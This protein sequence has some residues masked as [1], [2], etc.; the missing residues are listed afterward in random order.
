MLVIVILSLNLHA[1][2]W[3]YQE[4]FNS[5]R[6]DWNIVKGAVYD[7]NI[8]R[9][10][11]SIRLSAWI[12]NGRLGRV[13]LPVFPLNDSSEISIGAWSAQRMVFAQ[14]PYYCGILAILFFDDDGKLISNQK[15]ID[16]SMR[17]PVRLVGLPLVPQGLAWD[18]YSGKVKVPS[19]AKTARIVY[20][21]SDFVEKF[22]SA[23]QI[24]GEVW[25]DDVSVVF[26]RP[27]DKMILPE[28]EEKNSVYKL[29]L[30]TPVEINLFTDKDP[31]QFDLLLYS[32]NGKELSLNEL[33]NAIVKYQVKDYLYK[34]ITSGEIPFLENSN[35][36]TNKDV[37]KYSW[38]NDDGKTMS[39]LLKTILIDSN[40]S[41]NIGI[42]LVLDVQIIC[43]NKV[44]ADGDIAFAILK[45]DL[46]VGEDPY[47]FHFT[48]GHACTSGQ[49]SDYSVKAQTA[50]FGELLPDPWG[51]PEE[52]PSWI[53]KINSKGIVWTG[54]EAYWQHTMSGINDEPNFDLKNQ[55]KYL[56]CD[57]FDRYKVLRKA[58]NRFEERLPGYSYG[59]YG[60]VLSYTPEW[61]LVKKNSLTSINPD[62]FAKYISE[63]VKHVPA[64][65]F[66]PL[67][68]EAVSVSQFADAYAAAGSAIKKVDPRLK[69]GVCS[70]LTA[71]GAKE[72]PDKVLANADIFVDD[73]YNE[74]VNALPFKEELAK[75]GFSKEVFLQEH[76]NMAPKSQVGR[77]AAIIDY[78][79]Y[80]LAHGV[81]KIYWWSSPG[82]QDVMDD[83]KCQWGYGPNLR[84]GYELN[85]DRSA[86]AG[87]RTHGKGIW[88]G[89]EKYWYPFLELIAQYHINNYLGFSFDPEILNLGDG[90]E[91]YLFKNNL[92][93]GYK[94]KPIS[95]LVAKS[96]SPTSCNL[97]IDCNKTFTWRDV[98]GRNYSVSPLNGKI[99]LSLSEEPIIGYFDGVVDNL[100]ANQ[101]PI[102]FTSPDKIITNQQFKTS[103]IIKNTFTQEMK[104]RL[105]ISLETKWNILPENQEINLKPGE[106]RKFDFTVTVPKDAHYGE[107]LAYAILQNTRGEAWGFIT[108][109][110]NVQAPVEIKFN[111]VPA[112]RIGEKDCLNVEIINSGDTD[113]SG[114]LSFVNPITP[115]IRP[116]VVS[117]QFLVPA[118]SQRWFSKVLSVLPARTRSYKLKYIV[119]PDSGERI[120]K[121]TELFFIGIAATKKTPTIDAKFED[122]PLKELIKIQF[123]QEY[124]PKNKDWGPSDN[125][126]TDY[127]GDK[128]LSI[129]FY[130]QWD[131]DNL[132][133]LAIILD[134]KTIHDN[135]SVNP[136]TDSWRFDRLHMSIYPWQLDLGDICK[137]SAYKSEFG[138]GR[139]SPSEIVRR[140]AP[141]GN[142]SGLAGMRFAAR[143]TDAGYIFEGAYSRKSLDPLLLLPGSKFRLTMIFCDQDV[144][145]EYY[146]SGLMFFAGGSNVDGNANSFG[147]VTLKK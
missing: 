104:G 126:E 81:D 134:D 26:E 136:E 58:I 54:W 110:I 83:E 8:G 92:V 15:A 94:G 13:E 133:W 56:S 53:Q 18:Y 12:E 36:V 90:I 64:T 111:S 88:P 39:G 80:A 116:E 107:Y 108:K 73:I 105:N 5:Q 47:K 25:V 21:W 50:S 24:N 98:Y 9:S 114:R 4:R 55:Y 48:R 141:C 75:R 11:G 124:Y 32:S 34:T 70:P 101:G 1:D 121:E 22:R 66:I 40:V 14:D 2:D 99:I 120:E 6:S 127:T 140:Q 131:E 62:A 139:T 7:P 125:T 60:Q 144:P 49:N 33:N 71:A 96:Q 30:R 145:L 132:Y 63:M 117:F 41:L 118:K 102:T 142:I 84:G 23:E 74:R 103:V 65:I 46:G 43:D 77:A 129:D 138:V 123:Y 59:V 16:F 68:C 146:P 86:N 122:W 3:L 42:Y 95:I 87:W 31:L 137:G 147:Q 27:S 72:I 97:I 57:K 115:E 69:L 28:Q 19:K 76:C 17:T 10:G 44:I 61:A 45:P 52:Y 128:D 106:S 79:S 119:I 93:P 67:G 100:K 135:L 109:K 143:K 112:G 37:K 20:A 91:A 89:K 113:F 85:K 82:F 38:E 78:L 35:H 29:G 130:M 51:R